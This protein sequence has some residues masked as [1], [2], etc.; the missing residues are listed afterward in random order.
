ME[1][2]E[3]L[4]QFRVLHHASGSK[5]REGWVNFRCPFCG[6]DPYMGYNVRGR[7]VNCWSCGKHDLYHTIQLLTQALPADC[8]RFIAE[9]PIWLSALEPLVPRGFIERPWGAGPLA[10]AYGHRDYLIKRGF[11]PDVISSLWD[12]EAIGQCGESLL[13]WRLFIPICLRGEIVSWT[14][15]AVGNKEPRYLSAKDNQSAIPIE[16]LV[17]GIDYVR[18]T[19]IICEGPLD[20][21]AIGPGAVALCGLRTSP[22][23]LEQLSRI[24]R[25]VVCF[26]AEPVAQTR[27]R[28]LMADLSVFDGETINL[29]LETG[30][31]P[32]EA[33]KE[34]IRLIRRKYL[35]QL[36]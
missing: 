21:W 11:D 16:Q 18:G 22:S 14:T 10:Y 13:R 5:T 1:F 28:K 19:A 9:L 17:Y 29:C 23:Q 24:P 27:A 36:D 4:T 2:T 3:L 7:Y 31:D 8:H 26:D 34:E 6:K 33:S 20:A 32:A 30:K 25:R 35:D 15:R 12:V